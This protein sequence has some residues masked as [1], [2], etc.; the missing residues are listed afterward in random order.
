M[1]VD[2]SSIDLRDLGALRNLEMPREPG[3]ARAEVGTWARATEAALLERSS[4]KLRMRL[5]RSRTQGN[6]LAVCLRPAGRRP[7]AN[8]APGTESRRARRS[9]K[10]AQRCLESVIT[11]LVRL[12]V[13][14]KTTVHEATDHR[15]MMRVSHELQKCRATD[16]AII[17]VLLYDRALRRP[18]LSR[19]LVDAFR[20]ATSRHG[21]GLDAAWHAVR[22]VR[23]RR[24]ARTANNQYWKGPAALHA[25]QMVTSWTR[26][27]LWPVVEAIASHGSRLN[28]ETL[29]PKLESLPHFTRYGAYHFLRSLRWALDVPL[30]SDA[31]FACSMSQG[32]AAM[33]QVA[34]L[35]AVLRIV[36]SG[37]RGRRGAAG[38]GDAA[39]VLCEASKACAALGL[40]PRDHKAWSAD[41]IR[42]SF[43]EPAAAMLLLCL[44]K[45]E[46]L[47]DVV[48]HSVTCARAREAADL[49]VSL[50]ATSEAWDTGPHFCK[51][52]EMLTPCLRG[53]LK[54]WGW[55]R[56]VQELPDALFE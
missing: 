3:A 8:V 37:R 15:R 12:R 51:G 38:N 28:A 4:P 16:A 14:V 36:R 17:M 19:A 45:M 13:I 1:F 39:L 31:A 48:V 26:S 47:S 10:Q 24:L 18:C 46:P 9:K 40:I 2:N 55:Q 30:H 5:M 29:M 56:D 11:Q 41:G 33:A 20:H 32:V 23:R 22:S 50:P 52:A 43:S 7:R 53:Q 44:Q 35:S 6:R 21:T 54:R 42:R 34:P 25:V 49:E 27:M